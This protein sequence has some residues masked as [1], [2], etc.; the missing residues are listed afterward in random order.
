[1][2]N[3]SKNLTNISQINN[4]MHNDMIFNSVNNNMNIMNIRNAYNF[5]NNNIM[6]FNNNNNNNNIN[7]NMNM[8]NNINTAEQTNFVNNNFNGNFNMYYE[9]T[10]KENENKDN[11]IASNN[12][13]INQNN[14]ESNQDT[15]IVYKVYG[16]DNFIQE[17]SKILQIGNFEEKVIND[18]KEI[19]SS[20]FNF[21][22]PDDPKNVD[23]ISQ[24]LK[25]KYKGDWFVLSCH[26]TPGKAIEDFDFKFT[27]I[28][29]ENTL[30]FSQNKFIFYICKL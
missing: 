20:N 13:P 14:E 15:R 21:S 19:C 26:K 3:H 9:Y 24:L 28:K 8:M 18:I 16:N 23:I 5:A 27:N 11:N 22:K 2:D 30:I 10:K 6:N 17:E 7:N 4:Q 1:M 25:Q 29:D 12:E